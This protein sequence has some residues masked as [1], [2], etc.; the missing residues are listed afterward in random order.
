MDPVRNPYTP[1]AGAVPPELVGRDALLNDF[2]TMLRRVISGR[3]DKG[4]IIT[5][6]RGVGKTVLLVKM[7]E[8]ALLEGAVVAQHE[9]SKTEGDLR[10]KLPTL[11]RQALLEVSPARKWG[12]RARRAAS[13]LKNFKA[14]FDPS[15]TWTFGVELEPAEGVADSGYLLQDLP[16]MIQALGEAAQEAGRCVV[17]LIDELQYLD[18]DELSALVM[19]KH[20]VNQ[21][22]LP[23][24]F[25]GAGLPQLPALTSDAQTYAERMFNWVRVGRLEVVDAAQALVLPARAEGVEYTTEAI[26][27]IVE[28]TEG[29]PFFVQEYGKA[30]WNTTETEMISLD[31]A[32][33]AKPLVEQTLDSDFFTVRSS[34]LTE[35]ELEFVRTMGMRGAG[36]H[37]LGELAAAMGYSSSASTGSLVQRLVKKG[38]IYAPARGQVDFTVPQFDRYVRRRLA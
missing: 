23:V 1:N 18:S 15:G 13:I 22:R 30:V 38:I 35:K 14:T 36:P 34:V 16:A 19:A 24:V 32:A 2:T 33:A 25:A 28:Y 29:Y 8:I 9:A 11:I 5:G 31:T 7:H 37:V 6:L 4:F 12:A 21:W 27:F 26:D 3:D 17:F 20:R 10:R